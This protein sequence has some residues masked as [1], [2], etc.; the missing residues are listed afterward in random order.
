MFWCSLL[1]PLLFSVNAAQYELYEARITVNYTEPATGSPT[2]KVIAGRFGV[3]SPTEMEVGKVVHVVTEDSL[4]HG[5]SPATNAPAAG[6][7]WI[8]LIQR[9]NCKFEH[10]IA[11]AVNKNNASAVVIYNHVDE[12]ILITMDHRSKL[13]LCS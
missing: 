5:C 4:N 11:T 9:G 1:L 10:K 3:T 6:V 2:N 12:D 13:C 7:R 8:A